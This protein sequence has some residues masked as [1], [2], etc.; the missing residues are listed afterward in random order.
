MQ[1]SEFAATNSDVG[2]R[3]IVYTTFSRCKTVTSMCNVHCAR[4]YSGFVSFFFSF[5][6]H[7]HTYPTHSHNNEKK[8]KFFQRFIENGINATASPRIRAHFY[9]FVFDCERMCGIWQRKFNCLMFFFF[10]FFSFYIS[11]CFVCAAACNGRCRKMTQ[12]ERKEKRKI[13]IA[14]TNTF[15]ENQ[16][17]N[18]VM[19]VICNEC[20]G[21]IMWMW[22]IATCNNLNMNANAVHTLH[23]G[24]CW[25]TTSTGCIP[26]KRPDEMGCEPVF[27][28]YTHTRVLGVCHMKS[29]Q[30]LVMYS[31]PTAREVAVL[32][33]DNQSSIE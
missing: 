14:N 7:K 13:E 24:I 10:H 29:I 18:F 9:N 8:E 2:I 28:V 26:P 27:I 12:F 6:S 22:I 33:E 3:I 15:T 31:L 5:C 19:N 32:D 25:Y 23:K 30:L 17:M 21:N 16:R 4:I 1:Q 20:R 11:H